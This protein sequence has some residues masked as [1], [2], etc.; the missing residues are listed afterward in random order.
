M[1]TFSTEAAGFFF[2]HYFFSSALELIEFVM[3]IDAL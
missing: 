2:V 1:G 3:A